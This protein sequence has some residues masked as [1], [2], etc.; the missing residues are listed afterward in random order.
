MN[1]ELKYLPG[2]NKELFY[3]PAKRTL[4]SNSPSVLRTAISVLEKMDIRVSL[5]EPADLPL[6]GL[7]SPP[8][9]LRR[10]SAPWG[11][12]QPEQL[13]W[14]THGDQGYQRLCTPQRNR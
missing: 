5:D 8:A 11:R 10:A 6:A 14:P 7:P 4:A 12:R 13:S 3:T 2:Q 1:N 9:G